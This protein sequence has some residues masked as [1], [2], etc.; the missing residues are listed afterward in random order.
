MV[1]PLLCKVKNFKC[2]QVIAILL[3]LVYENC[4]MLNIINN[5]I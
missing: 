2:A 4:Y 5:L 3:E 1:F